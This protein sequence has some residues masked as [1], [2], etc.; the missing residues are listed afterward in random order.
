MTLCDGCENR[1]IPPETYL[2]IKWGNKKPTPKPKSF[3]CDY[4]DCYIAQDKERK[5]SCEGYTPNGFNGEDLDEINAE[6]L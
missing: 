4:H 2:N 6:A 1:T 5:K 3:Y